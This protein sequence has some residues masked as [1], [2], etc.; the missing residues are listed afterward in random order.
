MH[1]PDTLPAAG[2]R[3][4]RPV[5]LV[6]AVA[7]VAALLAVLDLRSPPSAAPLSVAPPSSAPAAPLR[8]TAETVAAQPRTQPERVADPTSVGPADGKVPDGVTVL[9]SGHPAVDRLDG[10]LLGALRTAAREAASDGV[11]LGVTSGWRSRAYQAQLFREAVSQHGSTAEAARWVAAPGTSAH[12]T[13]DAVDV[14]ATDAV[15]WLARHGARY[16]LCR[17]YDNEP[18]HYEHRAAAVT[19]GCPRP[20]ADPTRDPRLH[21]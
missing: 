18:W 3:R 21:R 14:G 20:Y 2:A 7:V 1:R 15:A 9:D 5:A 11:A 17:V 10:A 12:E 8:P 19:K 4:A 6:A 16:G 13:G